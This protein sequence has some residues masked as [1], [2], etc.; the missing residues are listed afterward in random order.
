MLC[1]SLKK[2]TGKKAKTFTTDLSQR[3][4][5]QKVLQY[6]VTEIEEEINGSGFTLLQQASNRGSGKYSKIIGVE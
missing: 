5:E 1:R 3:H 6:A 4:K 2:N